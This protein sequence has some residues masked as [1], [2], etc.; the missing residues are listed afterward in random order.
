MIYIYKRKKMIFCILFIL[1]F[2]ARLKSLL[3]GLLRSPSLFS[4]GG[5]FLR[6]SSLRSCLLS[7]TLLSGSSSFHTSRNWYQRLYKTNLLWHF[8]IQKKVSKFFFTCFSFFNI[9][10]SYFFD[11]SNAVFNHKFLK[12]VCKFL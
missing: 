8:F 1:T 11:F 10:G 5:C 9:E 2:Q 6:S 7:S 3:T 4:T 12:S